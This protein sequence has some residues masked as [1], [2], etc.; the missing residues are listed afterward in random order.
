[1]PPAR[2][3]VGSPSGTPGP[4]TR[5][6][7]VTVMPGHVPGSRASSSR[8]QVK[9]DEGPERQAGRL[10]MPL[11]RSAVLTGRPRGTALARR[12]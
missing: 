5:R 8:Q 11:P 6:R 4:G 3:I 1:M 7:G 9:S 2:C 10:K 12:G